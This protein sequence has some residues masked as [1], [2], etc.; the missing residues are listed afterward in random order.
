MLVPAKRYGFTLIEVIISLAIAGTMLV[1]LFG[2]F[3]QVRSTM[4]DQALYSNDG[5][6]GAILLQTLSRDISSALYEKW[7]H[8]K[9]FFSVRKNILQGKRADSLNFTTGSF[10]YHISVQH[11]RCYNV[12]YFGKPDPENDSVTLY[13]KEDVFADYENTTRGVSI[14]VLH[15]VEV[16]QI[17]L[18]D[19]AKTWQEAW[20]NKRLPRYV[21][22]TLIWI[23]GN[24]D[25]EFTKERKFVM[26]VS[27]GIYFR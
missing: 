19:D 15:N 3:F 22:I 20:D 13:R 24:K 25:A 7:N 23:E 1:A 26:Q 4:Q 6:D 27:P 12:T 8:N 21:R 17:E 2:I 14:P 5:E 11:A 18:S 10:Y 9:F 16:F